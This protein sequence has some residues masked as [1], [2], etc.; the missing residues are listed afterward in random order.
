MA[1]KKKTR[2]TRSQRRR[3]RKKNARCEPTR[4]RKKP[5]DGIQ[6]PNGFSTPVVKHFSS[7]NP[8][9]SFTDEQKRELAGS[10]G[11]EAARNFERGIEELGSAVRFHDPIELLSTAA[12]YCLHKGVGP[13]TDFTD[14]GPYPQ[15]FVEVLQSMCLR[16]T[17]DEFDSTAVLHPYLFRILDLCEQCSKAFGM[18]RFASFSDTA[19]TDRGLLLAIESARL[20]TQVMRNWGYPQHMRKIIRELLEPLESEITAH[21][22][23]GAI[24]LLELMDQLSDRSCERLSEFTRTLGVAFRQTNLR[25]MIHECCRLTGSS[26]ADAD[27]IFQVMKSHPGSRDE[28]RAFV[29]SYFHQLLPNL[30]LFTLEDCVELVPS[31]IDASQLQAVLDELSFEFGELASENVEHLMMQSKI[32]T[33]PL[34]KIDES[35]YFLPVNGLFNS[36]FLEIVEAW[37]KAHDNLKI[38]YHKRRATFL[39]VTL[40]RLLQGAFPGCLVRTGTTWVSPHDAKEYENDC[41]VVCGP[42]ALVFEAKSER[43]DDAAR[44]GAVKTLTDHYETLV[45]EPAEQASRF[46][47]LLEDGQGVTRFKTRKGDEYELNLSDIRRAICISVTL[48]SFPAATLCRRHL[49]ESGL[50][51]ANQRPAINLSL[52]DLMVALEVL[53]SPAIRLHY[54]WRRIEWEE[55]V[56]YLGDEE[57][58]LV[59][60]LSNGLVRPMAEDLETTS[61]F[62]YGN[63]VQLHRY[64]M[65]K[66]VEPETSI[67][68]P[69]RILTAW[70]SSLIRRIEA[71]EQPSK[72]DMACVLLDLCLEQQREFELRFQE[73]VQAV[74]QQGNEG[75]ENGLMFFGHGTEPEGAIVGFAYRRL[76]TTERNRQATELGAQAQ[77]ESH[78]RRVV[79]IGRDVERL[80]DPYDFLGVVETDEH[81]ND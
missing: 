53:E 46:A 71:L 72:W 3:A 76:S 48:D 69:R 56:I 20:Q 49:V 37:I 5:S 19:S 17:L 78:A 31:E 34:V 24:V 55:H 22:G 75:G 21:V 74:R 7:D 14:D 64:Y 79:I 65:A 39:E 33:R 18:K 54:L 29:L 51:E 52:S 9:A 81:A 6:L 58:L 41:L 70:W 2:K 38:R 60:Y 1:R 30:F 80:N 45:N 43:V 61:V 50:S 44:R 68:L 36:F 11:D 63:S 59:Y 10:I 25:K 57:D 16:F 32:R 8:F 12:V 26:E 15:A 73:L 47:G 27:H 23:V 67:P 40:E 42:V 62:L 77:E 4:E 13:S 66:W 35:E 28:K